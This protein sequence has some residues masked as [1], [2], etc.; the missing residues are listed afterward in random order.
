MPAMSPFRTMELK[1]VQIGALIMIVIREGTFTGVKLMDGA[2]DTTLVGVLASTGDHKEPHVMSIHSEIDVASYG[3]DW[4][5]EIPQSAIISFE[6]DLAERAGSA[7]ISGEK[8]GLRL[9]R[10]PY[11]RNSNGGLLDIAELKIGPRSGPSSGATRSWRLW[12]Q[13]GDR[14][15][16]GCEPLIDHSS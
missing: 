2:T 6:G 4:L 8:I 12:A 14:T 9:G 5:F 3:T 15:R 10:D 11:S 13:A 1:D 7:V 16:D